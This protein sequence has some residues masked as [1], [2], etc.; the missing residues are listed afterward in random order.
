M[1]RIRIEHFGPVELFDE[2]IA[3]VTVLIGPQASGKSTISKLIFFFQSIPDEW[4]NYLLSVRQTEEHNPFFEFN[5]RLRRKFVGYFGTTKHMKPFHIRYEYDVQKFVRLDLKDG[6]VQIHFSDPLKREI[7]EN[8]LHVV[9]LKKEMQYEQ[10]QLDDFW[11]VSSWKVRQQNVL[12]KV[13]AAITE[14]FGDSKTPIFI[15]AGRSLVAT[16]SD[17]LQDINPQQLDVLTEQFIE[18]INLLKKMFSHSFEEIIEDRKKFSTEKIDFE[19]IRLAIK[20]IEGVMK[21]KYMFSDYGERIFFNE[22]E[23]TKLKFSSSGQQEVVWI[24]LLI[25]TI[26][27]ERQRVFMVIEEPE[28]HLYPNAQKEMVA[29]FALLLNVTNSTLVVT[30][31]S[32]YIL[33]AFNIYLY[34]AK[35]G[36]KLDRRANPIVDRQLR[37]SPQRVKAYILKNE[38]GR[39]CYRSIMDDELQLMQAEAIDEASSAINRVLDELMEAEEEGK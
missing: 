19:A 17:Q 33:S 26:I 24:L 37:I 36:K 4:V 13:K 27:L 14:V 11:N 2:E 35:I 29:L 15:P 23:Y 25:F 5:K 8:F 6:Y 10:Q 16:L 1:A 12:E 20:M 32:P 39:F 30:T 3:D 22:R 38:G 18:R 31:H 7:Q 28:A 21:G 34:A 9:Q